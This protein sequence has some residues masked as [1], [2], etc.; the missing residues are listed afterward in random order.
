MPVEGCQGA[1]GRGQLHAIVGGRR[2][3]PPKL[4]LDALVDQQR[5]PAAGAGIALAGAIGI[6]LDFLFA[7]IALKLQL[8]IPAA[9]LRHRQRHQLAARLALA[10]AQRTQAHHQFARHQ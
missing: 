4:A 7:H 8:G 6:D 3:A 9:D 2:L 10:L 1:D 5:A